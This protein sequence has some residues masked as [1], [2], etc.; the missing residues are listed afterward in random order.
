MIDSCG[1]EATLNED[2][3]ITLEFI[4]ERGHQIGIASRIEDLSGAYQLINLLNIAPYIS[5]RE[6]YPGCKKKHFNR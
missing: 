6:I 2:T 1:R 4:K 5:Y 3:L